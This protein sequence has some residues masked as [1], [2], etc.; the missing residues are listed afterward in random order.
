MVSIFRAVSQLRNLHSLVGVAVDV[1]VRIFSTWVREV[2]GVSPN[3]QGGFLRHRLQLARDRDFHLP[4]FSG[5]T[6][7]S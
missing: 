4:C 3:A 2:L 7:S 1:E 6:E 5:Y